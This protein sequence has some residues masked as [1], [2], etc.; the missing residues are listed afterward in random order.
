MGQGAGQTVCKQHSQHSKPACLRPGCL[1]SVVLQLGMHA[2]MLLCIAEQWLTHNLL[3]PLLLLQVDCLR[4]QCCPSGRGNSRWRLSF[5]LLPLVLWRWS[6][7]AGGRSI[8]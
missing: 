1:A 6:W 4:Y 2:R 3:L 8:Q 5:L 7:C